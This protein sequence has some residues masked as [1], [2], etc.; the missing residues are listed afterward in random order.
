M[1]EDEIIRLI[2]EKYQ[3]EEVNKEVSIIYKDNKIFDQ[4]KKAV[5]GIQKIVNEFWM[6]LTYFEKSELEWLIY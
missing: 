6:N 2:N 4:P 1:A 3:L 5:Y